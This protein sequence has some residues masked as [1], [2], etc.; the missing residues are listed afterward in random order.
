MDVEGAFPQGESD[1]GEELY[2]KVPDGWEEFYPGNVVLTVNV[3]I[4]GMK[5]VGSCFYKTFVKRVTQ[6]LGQMYKRPKADLCLCFVWKE[7]R[8]SIPR[9]DIK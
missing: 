8:L 7:G 2:I 9:K 6:V 4:Y 1:D 5:Q 3:P